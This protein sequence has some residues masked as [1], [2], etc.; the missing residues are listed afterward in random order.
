MKRERGKANN[1]SSKRSKKEDPLLE[2]VKASLKDKDELENVLWRE[3]RKRRLE[4]VDGD[5]TPLHFAAIFGHVQLASLLFQSGFND[6]NAIN[7]KDDYTPLK[8]TCRFGHS[9]VASFLISKG[10][11]VNGVV[12][13][14]RDECYV[15]P[16]RCAADSGHFDLM[17]YTC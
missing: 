4:E 12:P 8:Y 7:D 11:F 17:S 9:D 16:I 10:A 2:A 13:A 15:S 6:V 3:R 1:E 14:D 5:L